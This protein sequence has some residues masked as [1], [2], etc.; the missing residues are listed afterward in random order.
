MPVLVDTNVISDILTNDPRW[1]TWSKDQ[2]ERHYTEGLAINPVIF[3]EL[4]VPAADLKEVEKLLKGFGLEFLEIPKPGL[5]AAGKA[6]ARYRTIGGTKSSPLPDFFIGGHAEASSLRL[7]TRD[8]SRFR[9]Y[10]PTVKVIAPD[11]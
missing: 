1:Q 8:A 2:L 3:A 5:F 10:F 4:S 7:I 11:S 9:T 6:F